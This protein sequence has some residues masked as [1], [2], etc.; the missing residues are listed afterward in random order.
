MSAFARA[1]GGVSA[2]ACERGVCACQPGRVSYECVQRFAFIVVI[3]GTQMYATNCRQPHDVLLDL[4]TAISC[5]QVSNFS[6]S[7]T[8]DQD[9]SD[10]HDCV[11]QSVFTLMGAIARVI[12]LMLS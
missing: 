2:S 9:L 11:C 10:G 4:L 3:K 1:I 5:F 8:D 7:F 6:V 12:A